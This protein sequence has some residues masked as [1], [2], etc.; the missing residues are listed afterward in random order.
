M[1]DKKGIIYQMN[2]LGDLMEKFRNAVAVVLLAI[3]AIA[4]VILVLGRE[5]NIPVVWLDEISTYSVIWVIF[6]GLALGYKN[7]MFPKV[8][9]I[10]NITPKSWKRYL[11][12]FWDLVALVI[13]ALVLWSGKDY[14]LQTYKSKTTSAQ[15]R[16][17]LY[18]VY[19][20]PILG[21]L[22][23]L[24]FTV[25]NILTN[26]FCRKEGKEGEEA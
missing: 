14:I 13:L 8:D 4:V 20:G 15:L 21:Y 17:P 1:S 24:Y 23:T 10:C 6:I 25:C 26:I 9:I 18:I 19:M 11:D 22:F 2:R 7:G 16:M 3:I 12:I 5:I